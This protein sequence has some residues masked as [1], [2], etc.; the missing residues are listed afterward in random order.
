MRARAGPFGGLALASLLFLAQGLSLATRMVTWSDESA[1]VHLGYLATTGKISLF[2]DEMTGSRMPLPFYVLGISQVLLG[3]SLMAARLTSLAFGLLGLWLTAMLARQ[4]AGNAA[5]LLAAFFLA[6]QGVV[7]GYFATATYHG[8]VASILLGGLVLAVGPRSVS[9][10]ILGM[11]TLSLLFFTRTNLWPV[12]PAALAGLWV[13]SRTRAERLLLLPA[14]GLVPLAFFAWDRRHVKILA[15]VPGLNRLTAKL[16]YPDPR[17]LGDLPPQELADRL[18]AV[19]RF[20][21]TYEFW[22]LAAVLLVA[23]AVVSRW[24]HADA[25]PVVDTQLLVLMGLLA[26]STAWQVELTWALPKAVVGYFPSLAPLLAV[27]LGVGFVRALARVRERVWLR[28]A[29]IAALAAVLVAPIFI[30]RHSLLPSGPEAHIAPRAALAAGADHLRRLIPP[31]ARVFLWGDSLLLYLAERRPYLRQIFSIQTMVESTDRITI[32]R[33]GL[34]G[35]PEM[36]R[37][38]GREADVVVL[39]PVLIDRHRKSRPSQMA[40]LEALLAEH[41]ERI[42][43]VTEYPWLVF[44]VYRRRG[45]AGRGRRRNCMRSPAAAGGR[46]E[47]RG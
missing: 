36:E 1:Y 2:Q 22:M 43:R 21:R 23:V 29:T 17:G 13:T 38:L 6:T 18:W 4:I 41:F 44:D 26:Y 12:L 11:A 30:V 25:P 34:W 10:R 33:S 27:I 37:W 24:R 16:G 46:P 45:P 14:A 28:H 7:V 32:E 31:E 15:N 40:R 47:G 39:E 20:A 42:D 3:R 5:G 35:T 8:L 9:S 19:V